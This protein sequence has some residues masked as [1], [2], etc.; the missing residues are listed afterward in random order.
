MKKNIFIYVFCLWCLFII[1]LV[2]CTIGQKKEPTLPPLYTFP[3]AP[4]H[5]CEV[6]VIYVEEKLEPTNLFFIETDDINEL[7]Q[8]MEDCTKRKKSASTI[9]ENAKALG[10]EENHSIIKL[11]K[12]EYENA[13]SL[14]K[15]YRS[16][17]DEILGPVWIERMNEYPVATTVWLYLKELGYS[18]YICA[19]IMGNLMAEVGGQTLN[20]DYQLYSSGDGYYGICQWSKKYFPEIHGADLLTQCDYLRDNIEYEINTFG[21]LYKKSFG[22]EKFLNMVNVRDAALAFAKTYER[23]GTGSYSV[24]Q[25]NAEKAYDYYVD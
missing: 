7:K 3:P 23:C 21:F 22:Y 4:A 1:L 25:K 5:V 2:G 13:S 16:I 24:R 15:Q 9:I 6:T 12:K 18:D 14:W 10:Y 8:L 20:L 11:A 19:A 17:Y